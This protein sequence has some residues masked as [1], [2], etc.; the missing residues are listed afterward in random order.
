MILNTE[1][2]ESAYQGQSVDIIRQLREQSELN[3]IKHMEKEFHVINLK[4]KL[5]STFC[6]FLDDFRNKYTEREKINCD[7]ININ[8]VP[9]CFKSYRA[10]FDY[11]PAVSSL[12]ESWAFWLI[13]QEAHI[14]ED[15]KETDIQELMENLQGHLQQ[16]SSSLLK[17]KS[18][19][20]HDHIKQAASRTDLHR[21]NRRE[22]YGAK[23][24]WQD[25]A[26]SDPF[27]SAV[28]LY[29]KAYV[30]INLRKKGYMSEGKELLKKAQ[31]L[32]DV[33]LSETTNTMIFCSLSSKSDFKIHHE[34]SNLLLQM[35]VRMNIFKSWK[36]Y[37]ESALE[38]I[39]E[40]QKSRDDAITED[41]STF[42][43]LEE[44]DFVT[45]NELRKMY[46]Y[47]LGIVFEVKRKP[48]FSFDSLICFFIGV[49]Q[50]LGGTL[51]CAFSFGAATNIGLGLISEG[52]SDMI[53]GTI[54][55]FK[56]SFSW[57]DWA[58][59]K[60]IS[61]GVSLVC[62]GLQ[63]LGKH[64]LNGLK[65]TRTLI[66]RGV[67]GIV[68]GT[69]AVP[70]TV[71]QVIKH[72]A[73][74]TAQE[75]GKQG[76]LA[77][78]NHGMDKGFKAI[79]KEIFQSA[80]K[81][82]VLSLVRKNK[83]LADALIQFIS[84]EVPKEAIQTKTDNFE[85]DPESKKSL[86]KSVVYMT[87]EVIPQLLKNLT[88][89]HE[90]INIL[91]RVANSALRVLEKNKASKIVA[92]I[93]K[94]LSA[95][96]YMTSVIEML[97]AVPTEGIINDEFIPQFLTKMEHLKKDEVKD[98]RQN[99]TDVKRLKEDF[100]QE[101]AECVSEA[102]V[103]AFVEHL[104]SITSRITSS[105]VNHK[106]GKCVENVL[107]RQETQRFFDDQR[108]SYKLRV[109][110]QA[111]VEPLPKA[112]KQ[113]L[114]LYVKSLDSYGIPAT[115]L[116]LHI[117]TE[118]N[119]LE[120][121]GI[122]IIVTNEQGKALY[123][124]YYPGRGRSHEDITLQLVK[125]KDTSEQNNGGLSAL[126]KR[127]RGEHQP[128]TGHFRVVHPDGTTSNVDSEGQNCLF[129]AIVQANTDGHRD[130]NN[131]RKDAAKLRR[132]CSQELQQNIPQNAALLRLHRQF[133]E[134]YKNPGLFTIIG[135][136][137]KT[138]VEDTRK[139]LDAINTSNLSRGQID[140]MRTFHL[141]MVA[142]HRDLK[143]ARKCSNNEVNADHI[144]P[145]DSYLTALRILDE[146]PRSHEELKNKRPNLYE[147]LRKIQHNTRGDTLLCMEVR[148]EHHKQ[149]L[150]TGNSGAARICR[151]EIA[152]GLA[153][154]DMQ[155]TLKKMF[156][157]S[158]PT[159]SQSLKQDAGI[160]SNTT[161]HS[162][163]YYE[164]GFR[165]M[166]EKHYDKGFI[167]S[168]ERDRLVSW[169]NDE[170]YKSQNTQEYKSLKRAL[171]QSKMQNKS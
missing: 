82:K 49:L 112:E 67:T 63:Y 24:Y 33:F 125:S 14:R 119:L 87:T 66:H 156:I 114:L 127:I 105:K 11:H 101:I 99:L 42:S 152:K 132:K 110:T 104:A 79:F 137:K 134:S 129:H 92:T 157:V 12:K 28:A 53:S 94:T 97:K 106:I 84:Q 74:Y 103:N 108:R 26:E 47:G 48:R 59:S 91:H 130:V 32:V 167:D 50:V 151:R 18:R 117:L 147:E 146:S 44:K 120:G 45:A 21:C 30:T 34:N 88:R 29:N 140:E 75:L 126:S 142:E 2:L 153:K 35:Q 145:K 25:A 70:V 154:G 160:N 95:A 68:S 159:T 136:T 51:V 109:A 168:S 93:T 100:I 80:F 83:A 76:V 78:V 57:A 170:R 165:L 1:Q 90:V 62:G 85:I 56:G 71:M 121:K 96:Q 3:H 58:I 122:R 52:V 162:A 155:E 55:I 69:R 143:S 65:N 17:G 39:V 118:S 166:I 150:T 7:G 141:G 131:L 164:V 161:S 115:A 144:P 5:F 4:Q 86:H 72:A 123:E 31:D 37:I 133:E 73:K 89:V 139:F 16:R 40:L 102:F 116:H 135:G 128:Y 64:G 10:K 6:G 169:V 111:P 41:S 36:G 149:A 107:G 77:A 60:S 23:Q 138:R 46:S 15:W 19:N 8:N 171:S 13:Q 38:K 61:I 163:D 81:E 158:H 98:G 43:L 148:T 124:E 27:F 113:E 54:G 9:E 22:C 20:F